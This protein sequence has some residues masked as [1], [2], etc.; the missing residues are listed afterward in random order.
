[1]K[2]TNKVDLGSELVSI[3]TIIYP[4]IAMVL[5]LFITGLILVFAQPKVTN[6]EYFEDNSAV[7]TKSILGHRGHS[8]IELNTKYGE[9]TVRSNEYYNYYK[10]KIGTKVNA[11]LEKLTYENGTTALK[12]YEVTPL[13]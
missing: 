1:M 9:Q 2:D 12:V 8:Q 7:V 3:K 10:D 11:K 6:T 5:T 4:L 13:G